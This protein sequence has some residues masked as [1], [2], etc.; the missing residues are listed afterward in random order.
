M[1]N[2]GLKDAWIQ[3]HGYGTTYKTWEARKEGKSP[4]WTS[5]DHILISMNQAGRVSALQVYDAP[6]SHGMEHSMITAA[7]YIIDNTMVKRVPHRN[8]KCPKKE[9]GRLNNL[10]REYL[11][12]NG[13]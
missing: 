8:L 13:L 10:I 2:A 9:V 5:P 11:P 3:R 4:I 1:D 12:G 6:L 7:I